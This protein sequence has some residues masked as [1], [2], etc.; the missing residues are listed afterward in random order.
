MKKTYIKI[1]AGL[2]NQ[3]FQYCYGLLR[4][5][6]GINVHYILAKTYDKNGNSYDITDVFN[7]FDING[8]LAN[9]IFSPMGK[10]SNLRIIAKKIFAKYIIGSYETDFYQK[11]DY[12]EKLTTKKSIHDYIS[13]RN[14]EIYMQTDFFKQIK[15]C[16]NSVSMHIR[17]G[18]YLGEG[19]PFSGI[20]TNEYYKNAIRYLKERLENPHFFIFT[21]DRDFCKSIFNPLEIKKEDYT[22][23]N[24]DSSL[25]DDP[26][27]DLFLM[28]TC[29][30]NII[31]NSTYSWWGAYLNKNEDKLVI[32][33][34]KWTNTNTPSLEEIK[35]KNWIRL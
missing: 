19:S 13:F 18:D 6:E 2:G 14:K 25:K 33:P 22:I 12:I 24:D 10:F 29:N 9:N 27:Y 23:I 11:A 1:F 4:Q 17:G 8:A 30:N 31:A 34:D 16:K 32:T 7:L 15:N 21:N 26:G 35:P 3:I 20:C 5:Q 28:S